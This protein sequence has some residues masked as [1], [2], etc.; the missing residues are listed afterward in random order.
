MKN[1]LTEISRK[2]EHW[3]NSEPEE[4]AKKLTTLEAKL[5]MMHRIKEEYIDI[6]IEREFFNFAFLKRLSFDMILRT[7]KRSLGKKDAKTI[8]NQEKDLLNFEL[9]M[10]TK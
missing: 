8:W 7:A 4:C 6:M 3:L 9:N 2:H 1:I 5:L 10:E